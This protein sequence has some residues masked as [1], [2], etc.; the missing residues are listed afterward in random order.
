MHNMGAEGT[1]DK[2]AQA[3][4]RHVDPKHTNNYTSCTLA[5]QRRNKTRT[6][7]GID[8]RGAKGAH[9]NLYFRIRVLDVLHL[10][11]KI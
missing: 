10:Q 4:G 5:Q 11:F 9:Q 6:Y 3:Q 2:E 8:Y 1:K 7:T